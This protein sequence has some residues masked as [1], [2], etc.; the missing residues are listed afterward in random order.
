MREVG[1]QSTLAA[2]PA[3]M[4]RPAT[5]VATSFFKRCGTSGKNVEPIVRRFA[6]SGVEDQ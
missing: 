3:A 4:V 6:L 5:D 1:N 2:L